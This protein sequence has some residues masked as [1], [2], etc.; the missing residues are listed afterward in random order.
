MPPQKWHV[1][2]KEGQSG[3]PVLVA[4]DVALPEGTH[5]PTNAELKLIF[6][7]GNASLKTWGR[8]GNFAI[9]NQSTRPEY[10]V[11]DPHWLAI[12]RP[13]GLHTDP[14]YPRYSHQLLLRG[15][16]L[17]ILGKAEEEVEMGRGVFYI[18]DGHSPHEVRRTDPNNDA[19][20][21]V[22]ASVDSHAPLNGDDILPVLIDYACTAQFL[23]DGVM[24]NG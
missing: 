11:D 5:Y 10:L 19:N 18:L 7:S 14:A 15:E 6:P 9:H 21:Y 13:L 23:P 16:G 20:W 3:W 1:P 17:C 24:P 12:H 4:F 22:A 2:L 8:G